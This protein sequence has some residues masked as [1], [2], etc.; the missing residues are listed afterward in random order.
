MFFIFL[1]LVNFAKNGKQVSVRDCLTTRGDV[2]SFQ[3]KTK[4]RGK[5]CQESPL[6]NLH[7]K[8]TKTSKSKKKY[9]NY[10]LKYEVD[11]FEMYCDKTTNT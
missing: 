9:H 5:N 1:K 4:D 3:E 8:H 2:V 10:A 11:N 6:K 7:V